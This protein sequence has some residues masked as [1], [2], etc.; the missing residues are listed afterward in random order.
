MTQGIAEAE[1]ILT[2]L[3]EQT[4]Q[5]ALMQARAHV[6]AEEEARLKAEAAAKRTVKETPHQ[7]IPF[8]E[9]RA[10]AHA[11]KNKQKLEELTLTLQKRNAKIKN[12]TDVLS[13]QERA[14]E[15]HK[16]LLMQ[17]KKEKE[18]HQ[19]TLTKAQQ[20][21]QQLK[22]QYQSRATKTKQEIRQLKAQLSQSQQR[23]LKSYNLLND[24]PVTI[25]DKL[26]PILQ[27]KAG[28]STVT[29]NIM[30]SHY[31]V[32]RAGALALRLIQSSDPSDSPYHA[33][34]Q[35]ILAQQATIAQLTSQLAAQPVVTEMIK[36]IPVMINGALIPALQA[37][38]P[39][40][41]IALN[42]NGVMHMV[43]RETAVKMGLTPDYGPGVK[44]AEA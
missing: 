34:Q 18:Q 42:I 21:I 40:N 11:Q 29:L 10:S 43:N 35:Q 33:M 28:Q 37:T 20:E 9:D 44:A 2:H 24:I 41:Q 26:I 6:Q 22:A 27:P 1:N 4:V 3:S 23:E 15:R 13:R 25:N 7:T 5:T 32:D 36:G 19:E 8:R 31:Q 12:Q 17:L 39:A 14:L 38:D 30:G 16:K